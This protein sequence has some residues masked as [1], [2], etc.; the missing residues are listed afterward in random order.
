LNRVAFVM[1][2][3]ELGPFGGRAAGWSMN[4]SAARVDDAARLV[5][6]QLVARARGE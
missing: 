3:E 6:L 4:C 5:S 2:L 1:G